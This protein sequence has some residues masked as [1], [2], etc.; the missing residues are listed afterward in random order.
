M[1]IK[2]VRFEAGAMN[3]APT[4]LWA[5]TLHQSRPTDHTNASMAQTP[6]K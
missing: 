6:L 3:V 2:P 5:M 1:L 4:M